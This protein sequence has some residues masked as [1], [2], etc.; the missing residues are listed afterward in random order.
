VVLEKKGYL[1]R[2]GDALVL[3]AGEFTRFLSQFID[4]LK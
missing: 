2:E 4:R 3:F 1:A